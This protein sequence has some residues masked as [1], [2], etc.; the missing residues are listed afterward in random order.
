MVKTVAIPGFRPFT[1]EVCYGLPALV[2]VALASAVTFVFW[3]YHTP[4]V[5]YTGIKV[6]QVSNSGG[7]ITLRLEKHVVWD[8][9]CV[10]EAEQEIR[11]TIA[12]DNPKSVSSQPIKLDGHVI[13]K[14]SHKGSNG[15]KGDPTPERFIVLPQ[16]LVSNGRW[17]FQIKA[18]MSCWIW[19]H[20][21]PIEGSVATTEFRVQVAPP[22]VQP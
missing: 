14:P 5:R 9:L 15:Q 18:K 20:L 8:R 21:W 2:S 3:S 17:Q 11:P 19:E 12:T 10:G 4:P 22:A 6:E 1:V 7:F 13:N 16:G